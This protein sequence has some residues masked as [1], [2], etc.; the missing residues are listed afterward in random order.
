MEIKIDDVDSSTQFFSREEIDIDLVAHYSELL[1]S[2]IKL[3]P[4]TVRKDELTGKYIILDGFH[5]F[6]ASLRTG[7]ESIEA[8]LTDKVTELDCFIEAIQK[9]SK[10]GKPLTTKDRRINIIR[11]LNFDE[12][13]EWSNQIIA[14][15]VGASDRT[16]AN[17]KD[18]H[19]SSPKFSGM[20]AVKCF[21]NGKPHTVTHR[22]DENPNEG[23]SAPATDQ[24]HKDQVTPNN[25]YSGEP[26]TQ[27]EEPELITTDQRID[28]LIQMKSL[29]QKCNEYAKAFNV[30]NDGKER[31]T[32]TVID[33][34]KSQLT[35][36]HDLSSK[37]I[38]HLAQLE[39][40][41]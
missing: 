7:V 13:W 8:V 35:E 9:N 3:P 22:R 17:I 21:R 14:S 27:V 29:Q 40:R 6:H 34:L 2:N 24:S 25:S 16:V 32:L 37:M 33:K 41:I 10:H 20:G 30:V 18:E 36:L 5:T 39:E 19:P 4:I 38:Q 31:V 11:I 28:L 26:N 23:G 12:S 15:I 1:E